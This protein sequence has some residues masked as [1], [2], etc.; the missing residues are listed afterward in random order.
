V[1]HQEPPRPPAPPTQPTQPLGSAVPP[2]QPLAAPVVAQ[3]VVERLPPELPP[4]GPWWDNP[5]PAILTGLLCLI[6]GG[7]IGYAIGGKGETVTEAQRE[8]RAA[9]THTVTHTTTVVRPKVVVHTNTVTARTVTQ[10]PAPVNSANEER[11]T[12]AEAN[13]RRAERENS[14]LKRQAEEN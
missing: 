10:T 8:R 11:R 5:W 4:D 9:I 14:E 6:V 12:E 2:R 13:L 3:P 7:L 1:S